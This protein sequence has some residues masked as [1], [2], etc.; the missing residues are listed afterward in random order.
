MMYHRCQ[1]VGYCAT[2]FKMSVRTRSPRLSWKTHISS[3]TVHPSIPDDLTLAAP[4]V[5]LT[6]KRALTRR[7][8]CILRFRALIFWA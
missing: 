6:I 2:G 4:A 5:M 1:A 7:A 3:P 8:S